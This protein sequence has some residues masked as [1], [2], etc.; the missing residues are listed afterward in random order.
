MIR[1]NAFSLKSCQRPLPPLPPP[2]R[3][4]PPEGREAPPPRDWAEDRLWWPLALS[5]FTCPPRS[6][7]PKALSRLVTPGPD[8]SGIL[9][10]PWAGCLFAVRSDTPAPAPVLS[11]PR[12]FIRLSTAARFVG[13]YLS[14]VAESR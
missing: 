9:F 13:E 11:Y 6:M 14:R 5:R 2:P 1:R 3:D 10:C 12:L 4:I 7:P 8:R